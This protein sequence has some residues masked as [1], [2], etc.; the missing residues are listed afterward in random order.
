MAEAALGLGASVVAFIGLAGQVLQGCH[1]VCDF[2]DLTKSAPDDLQ[3]LKNEIQGFRAAILVFQKLI[4]EVGRCARIE[5]CAEQALHALRSGNV[6]IEE[7]KV[8]ILKLEHDGCMNWWKDIRVAGKRREFA[9]WI[10][11]LGEAKLSLLLAQSNTSMWV[12]FR[13]SFHRQI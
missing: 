7:L 13:I 1:Y 4:G 3:H 10:G 6:A 9:K 11:R 5:N 2:L 8:L 12:V